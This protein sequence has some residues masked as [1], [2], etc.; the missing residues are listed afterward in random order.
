[1]GYDRNYISMVEGGR[2][3]GP[4]FL[5]LLGLLESSPIGESLTSEQ[6]L[7]KAEDIDKNGAEGK[8]RES[9]PGYE[10]MK[11][12]MF[13]EEHGTPEQI[14]LARALLKTLREQLK[15]EQSG[16]KSR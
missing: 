8:A 7:Q 10:T 4:K 11:H 6:A 14:A 16:D 1:M 9:E 5:K 3:P 15:P 13:I 12:I 2:E